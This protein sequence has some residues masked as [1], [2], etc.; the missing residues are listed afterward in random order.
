MP[1][2]KRFITAFIAIIIVIIFLSS[3]LFTKLIPAANY[4]DPYNP[5][6]DD[7]TERVPFYN[8]DPQHLQPANTQDIG[9]PPIEYFAPSDSTGVEFSYT[10][11]LNSQASV[12]IHIFNE[13]GQ[14]VTTL[15]EDS[16][17]PSGSHTIS[18]DGKDRQGEYVAEGV[19]TIGVVDGEDD[20]HFYSTQKIGIDTICPVANLSGAFMEDADGDGE[21]ELVVYG[22]AMD[23]NLN[24][25]EIMYGDEKGA[26][27]SSI[28]TEAK[29]EE[30]L[31]SLQVTLPQE[32]SYTIGLAVIDK[33]GNRAEDV[34]GGSI[35]SLLGSGLEIKIY[36]VIQQEDLG[37]LDLKNYPDDAQV[38]V[39]DT[40]PAGAA[41][42]RENWEWSNTLKY[43][44]VRSHTHEA[45]IGAGYHYFI[46]PTES[47]NIGGNN[48][49]N[50]N[51]I[52]YVYLD[53]EDPPTQIML[54]Y[55]T[56][57]GN[58]ER[59]VYWGNNKINLGGTDGTISQLRMDS[60]P[61]VGKWIRLKIPA[62]LLELEGEEIRGITFATYDGTA[63]WDKTTTS[64][65]LFERSTGTY[66][67][68]IQG[69]DNTTP[70][71]IRFSLSQQATISLTIY[72]QEN[73]VIRT[74]IDNGTKA[75][76][77]YEIT[78]DNKD[79]GGSYVE[80]GSYYYQFTAPGTPIDSDII[81]PYGVVADEEDVAELNP[82]KLGIDSQNHLYV[83]NNT[84]GRLYVFDIS[85][86]DLLYSFPVNSNVGGLAVDA[87]PGFDLLYVTDL[88]NHVV[89]RYD[90]QGTVLDEIGSP[91]TGDGQFDQPKDVVVDRSGK[92]Y[93]ADA[94]N[95]R[96]QIFSNIG[97]FENSFPV[98]V[99]DPETEEVEGPDFQPTIQALDID[100]RG[101]VYLL[102][103]ANNT[104][105]KYNSQGH[106][107]RTIGASG[108]MS[109]QFQNPVDFVI[110]INGNLYIADQMNHRVQKLDGNGFCLA[111]L[112]SDASIPPLP[113]GIALHPSGDLFVAEAQ[114][115]KVEQFKVARAH[116]VLDNI[117]ARI[118]S[119]VDNSLVAG[120]VAIQGTASARN[121]LKY[122]V[123]WGWGKEPTDWYPLI[124]SYSEADNRYHFEEHAAWTVGDELAVFD[125]N[126][127]L[128]EQWDVNTF[129]SFGVTTVRLMVYA[130]DGKTAE[131]RVTVTWG[132]V[133]LTSNPATIIS[134]DNKVTLTLPSYSVNTIG[135]L[136]ISITPTDKEK[137]ENVDY[138]RIGEFYEIRPPGLPFTRPVT[139]EMSYTDEDLLGAGGTIDETKLRIYKW[140]P[141]Q[142]MWKFLGGEI[143]TE[144]NRLSAEIKEIS[145]GEAYYVIFA[146]PARINP[147][148]FFQPPASATTEIIALS[149]LA[150]PGSQVEI[151]H[152]EESLGWVWADQ[153]NGFFSREGVELLSG[154]NV[155]TAWARDALDTMS[156]LSNQV[157]VSYAP[158][159]SIA[160]SS[161]RFMSPDYSDEFTGDI[162]IKRPVFI[163]LAGSDNDPD[164]I[165]QVYIKIF[166][167]LT[168]TAGLIIPLMET[169]LDSG[170][171]RNS[172]YFGYYTDP[173]YY[174]LGVMPGE[175]V[176][177]VSS[178][179]QTV[180][181]T[182][183]VLD[184]VPPGAPRIT[185]PT[186]PS[187]CQDTFENGQLGEWANRSGGAGGSLFLDDSD[188]SSGGS[189][190]KIV[191][192]SKG[193]D[194][195]VTIRESAYQVREYPVVSFNYKI[196]ENVRINLIVT[197]GGV[198]YELRMSDEAKH[199]ENFEQ[200]LYTTIGDLR[201]I[202]DGQWH[203]VEFNLYTLLKNC[204]PDQFDFRVDEMIM[205][206]WDV[207]GW[208]TIA[209]GNHNGEG[210]AYY[211]DNFIISSGGSAQD[212]TLSLSGL[213][214]TSGITD[215][216]FLLD[217]V[218][219]TLPDEVSEGAEWTVTYP[220]TE[221]GRWFFHARAADGVGNWGLASDY[222]LK[223]DKE[224]PLAQDPLPAPWGF[225]ATS[226]IS[227]KIMDFGGSGL[228]IDTV[229]LEVEGIVYD[230]HDGGMTYDPLT[231]TLSLKLWKVTSFTPSPIL[232][233]Q[234][235]E[236]SVIA[237][238]DLAGNPIQEAYSWSWTADYSSLTEGDLVLLTTGGGYSPSWSPDGDWIAFVSSNNIFVIQSDDYAEEEGSL[239]Q[240]TSTIEGVRNYDPAWS[241]VDEHIAFVSDREGD[242]DIWVVNS[243]GTDLMKLSQDDPD[244]QYRDRHPTWSP[245]GSQIA[246]EREGNIWIMNA[247][248]SDAYPLT[249][250]M[251]YDNLYPS[252]SSDGQWIVYTKSLY[253]DH[254]WMIGSD[255]QQ[256]FQ[257]T[258][259]DPT[260]FASFMIDNQRIVYE[261]ANEIWM[262]TIDG[263]EKKVLLDNR[264]WHDSE[265]VWNSE[266]TKLALSSTR[267]GSLNIWIMTVL[268][269]ADVRAVSEFISPNGDGRNDTVSLYYSP[270]ISNVTV[271]LRVY[272]GEGTL[273]K[274]L[275]DNERRDAGES[276]EMWDGRDEQGLVVADGAYTL[277]LQ[278][279]TPSGDSTISENKS[280]IIDTLLPS[281]S[282]KFGYPHKQ[283]EGIHYLTP[284]S[285]ITLEAAGT[286]SGV[287]RIEYSLDEGNSWRSYTSSFYVGLQ[288]TSILYRVTDGAGNQRLSN[289]IHISVDDTPPMSEI[290]PS[291]SLYY[292]GTNYYAPIH[293]TYSLYAEDNEGGAGVAG[294]H[295]SING[296]DYFNY[297]TPISLTKEG[298]NSI[299]Y[300]AVDHLDNH[301]SW[302]TIY[303]I[304]DT[305]LATCTFIPLGDTFNNGVDFFSLPD[306]LYQLSGT[307]AASG[308][309][310]MEY[311][312]D[313]GSFEEYVTPILIEEPGLHTLYY[314][315]VD[316]SGNWSQEQA[317]LMIV[318]DTLPTTQMTVS[319]PLYK[320]NGVNY[321]HSDYTYQITSHAGSVEVSID[322]DLGQ[323][324]DSYPI[325]LS[326]A[327]YG[328]GEHTISFHGEGEPSS[329]LTITVDHTSPSST[330]SI[331]PPT[332]GSAP[333]YITSL[334]RITLSA[335]DNL[336]GVA[337]MEYGVNS[338]S[339][340]ILYSQPF[341]ISIQGLSTI[342]F[343]SAD[344][345]G[346][347]EDIQ[348]IEVY[349]DDTG[350]LVDDILPSSSVYISEGRSF[351]PGDY[352]YSISAVDDEVGLDHIE[353]KINNGPY[354][355][356]TSPFSLPRGADVI[357]YKA[358]DYLGNWSEEKTYSIYIDTI[359]P[360]TT[361]SAD[362]PKYG[363]NPIYIST[364]SNI[365]FTAQDGQGAGVE[366]REYSLDD[367][368][369]WIRYYHPFKLSIPGLHSIQFRS[370]DNVGNEEPVQIADVYLDI[371]APS[372]H[373]SVSVPSAGID[374][375]YVAPASIVSLSA[376]DAG[377][378]VRNIE[379]KIDAGDWQSYFSGFNIAFPGAHRVYHRATDNLG[380]QSP[381]IAA[382]I[383]VD[384]TP[385]ITQVF[386]STPIA[387]D[388]IRK[389]AISSTSFALVSEDN[390]PGV[391]HIEVSVDEGTYHT[392]TAPVSF[393]TPGLHTISFYAFDQL[394]NRESEQ[395]YE[396]YCADTLPRVAIIP[397]G[398]VY[399]EEPNRYAPSSTM[400]TLVDTGVNILDE[401]RCQIDGGGFITYSTPIQLTEEGEHCI[402]FAAV[403]EGLQEDA[404]Q[405][406]VII[407]DTPP[408]TELSLGQPQYSSS[409]EEIFISSTT[410]IILNVTEESSGLAGLR[411]SLDNG[412]TWL[413]YS[414]S[415][416]IANSGNFTVHYQG[417]D[418][419]GNY[420][421]IKTAHL[422]VDTSP[423]TV[424]Y[425]AS[426]NLIIYEANH[427][428]PLDFSYILSATDNE[429]GVDHI[430]CNLDGLGFAPYTAPISFNG[431]G[432]H[433]IEFKAL[434]HLRLW[435]EICTLNVHVADIGVST[436]IA[437][438]EITYPLNNT[439]IVSS[440]CVYTLS[441]SS[442]AD[443]IDRIEYKID[444]G[445][446]TMYN[447]PF[448]IT[449]EG[450]HV[451]TYRGVSKTG[452]LE[453]NN[454]YRVFVDNT[455][456]GIAA[457][458]DNPDPFTPFSELNI[459]MNDTVSITAWISDNIFTELNVSLAIY[460]LQGQ[461]VR[462]L[463]ENREASAGRISSI[464]DG[465]SDSGEEMAEGDYVYQLMAA[466]RIGNIAHASG[467]I[468][469]AGSLVK[470]PVTA[471]ISDQ[472]Y[473]AIYGSRIVWEDE[474]GGNK[475]IYLY[476]LETQQ[477]T[478]ITNEA[479]DQVKPRI[480]EDFV[481]W[482]DY[483]N[484]NA[485]IY[486]Y[487]LDTQVEIR[488]T[489]DGSEQT[490]PSIH[491]SLIVWSDNRHG[492]WDIYLYDYFTG[493]ESRIT[494][495]TS[496]Q[497]NPDI[498]GY[499]IVWEDYRHGQADIYLY[500]IL[501]ESAEQRITSDSA[502]HTRPSIHNHWIVWQDSRDGNQDLYAYNLLANTEHVVAATPSNQTMPCLFG[503]FVVYQDDLNGPEDTDIYLY[504][505]ISN[506]NLLLS[507]HLSRQEHP[508]IY[509]HRIVWQDNRAG[510]WD[511]YTCLVPELSL[512]TTIRRVNLETED[513]I[514]LD[515]YGYY[516]AFTDY[517]NG[518]GDIYLKD[519]ING[520]EIRITENLTSTQCE[521]SVSGKI[522]VWQ[523]NRSG[524]WDI[525]TRRL[526]SSTE[527]RITEDL[528][529]QMHPSVYEDRIV[530]EDYRNGNSDIYYFD[531]SIG[532]ERP[533][534]L[535]PYNQTNPVIY[536]NRVVWIDDRHE[537]QSDVYLY[538]L[539]SAQE[540][541]I[542]TDSAEQ[543]QA[544]IY[545]SFVIWEDYRHG[546][547]DIYLY[548]II[549]G[550]ERQLCADISN[551]TNPAIY[552]QTIVWEDDTFGHKDIY[553]YNI[554][555]A[556]ARLVAGESYDEIY[557]NI[558]EN[559]IAWQSHQYSSHIFYAASMVSIPQDTLPPQIVDYSITPP[560]FSPDQSPGI[561]DRAAIKFALED[562]QSSKLATTV[563]IYD[564]NQNSVRHLV[565]RSLPVREHL[566]L[567]D[568]RDDNEDMVA[569]GMYT[570]TINAIDN[571][572]LSAPVISHTV[573]VDNTN[574]TLTIDQPSDGSLINND[575]PS[576]IGTLVDNLGI[577][578]DSFTLLIDNF[579]VV[580]VF[581]EES[582]FA[583][584]PESA[585]SENIHNIKAQVTDLA[586]NTAEHVIAVTVDITQPEISISGVEEGVTYSPP[587]SP[588]IEVNDLHLDIVTITLNNE[589]FVSGTSVVASGDH[590]LEVYAS[591]G[592]GN[593]NQQIV[594]FSVSNESPTCT[595]IAPYG[596]EIW[597]KTQDII[598][599]AE[600]INNDP[601]TITLSWKI[602]DGSWT[603]IVVDHANTGSFG[604]DTTAM[605]DAENYLV[606]V[607]AYDGQ[608]YAEDI[609]DAFFTIKNNTPPTAEAGDDQIVN[610]GDIV[611]FQGS[612]K[613]PDDNANIFIWNFGDGHTE[614]GTLTPT[615][616]YAD[617]GSYRVT[618]TV[619]DDDGAEGS[620]TLA[621]TVNN[622]A[623]SVNAGEDQ[624]VNKGN[625]VIFFGRFTDPGQDT[626][627]I[628]WD[629]GDGTTSEGSLIPTH[630]YAEVDIYRVTL[631]VTD[632]DGGADSDT[633]IITVN[634]LNY[635]PS[636]PGL[637]SPL[638][639]AEVT[640][641]QPPLV[642]ENSA[643]PD[644]DSIT[645]KFEVYS[646]EGMNNLLCQDFVAETEDTTSWVVS[647][648]LSD[649][650]WYYWRTRAT[651]GMAFS[652]WVSAS[653]FVNKAN[654]PPTAITMVNPRDTTEVDTLA[655]TLGVTNSTDI[656]EDVLNYTFEVYKDSTMRC[657]ITS[658][659]NI[660]EGEGGYTSWTVDLNL[661]D[662][663]WY[664][665]QATAIDEHG[666]T[667]TTGLISFFVNTTNYAP[668]MQGIYS[669]QDAEEVEAP[670]LDLVLTINNALDLDNDILTYFFEL[671]RINTFN[672]DHKQIS[673]EWPEG[674]DKTSWDV[675][676]LS[677][678]TLYFWRAKASDTLA[679]SSWVHARFFVNTDNDPP[680][681]PV[682]KNPGQYSWVRTYTPRLEL[683]PSEDPD[684]DLRNY[685]FEVYA[686]PLRENIIIHEISSTPE[687]TLSSE[688]GDNAWYYW[689]AQAQDEHGAASD[690]MET[691]TF[692]VK[693]VNHTPSAPTLN[694]PAHMSK[695]TSL[696]PLLSVNNS[697]D[698]DGDTITYE[699]EIYPNTDLTPPALASVNEHAEGDSTTSWLCEAIL[700]G[701]WYSWRA[702]AFDGIAYSE[703]MEEA[704]FS[705]NACDECS[706]ILITEKAKVCWHHSD[707]HVDGNLNFP[708][709]I[710]M[711]NLSPVGSIVIRLA[712]VEIPEQSVNFEIT[713]KKNDKWEYKD[714]DNLYGN[715]KDFKI[716]WKGAKFD[717]HGDNKFHIHTHFIAGTETELCI[718]TDHVSETLA[719]II[720]GTSIAYDEN[721]TITTAV[722]YEPQKDD[723]THVHFT[724][725]FQLTSDMT[726]KISGAL[727]LTINVA[728]YYKE[729]SAKFKLVSSFDSM[730]FPKSS[731]S[732]PD[733]LEYIIWFG[734]KMKMT[735]G[736]DLIGIEKAW[737]KKDTKHWEYK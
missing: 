322:D 6:D 58:G 386:P 366:L 215:F 257:L 500:D 13:Q 96:V 730:L 308:I 482:E 185:S 249:H 530:W 532:E 19:Y 389:Y 248:G 470:A 512:E 494:P 82:S 346:S 262:A 293:F 301:E 601:V 449:T 259:E 341:N 361:I 350:P 317:M 564:L 552:A 588:V 484:G 178:D 702:R 302:Q 298:L 517:T 436:R 623:P 66:E 117:V 414:R 41:T 370:I 63:Y 31:G 200:V 318:V 444:S 668:V 491:G 717:Y 612:F 490:N 144:N 645:Y 291:G 724:L 628:A 487:E 203:E 523:D 194:M 553:K 87:R 38:Y 501:K 127:I 584:T 643:D 397:V 573:S 376:G 471:D 77:Y 367:G 522:L 618:L 465:L 657:L 94:G 10:F 216:S 182:I 266:G 118:I 407:D 306:T 222:Q 86:G 360:Q 75:A 662:N 506:D 670:E 428:A 165:N 423:P 438:S 334:S 435:S 398:I 690:W 421:P 570:I 23:D 400:Y 274:T 309:H 461:L 280:I 681:T 255:G 725:P 281:A 602:N 457:L 359:A 65:D 230:I 92:L 507:N 698:P 598:W 159:P 210:A 4:C 404:T 642:I 344:N 456:P 686:D 692:F 716:D 380:Y 333:V 224:G 624:I 141:S 352:T 46:H 137:L 59:R 129:N 330:L 164:K 226:E 729:S 28:F 432:S 132:G 691:S 173:A 541:R 263:S 288:D 505:I 576:I 419:A 56:G 321:A 275:V 609:S 674:S 163:E 235:V 213:S 269:L 202:N 669:P 48:T 223:V 445:S 29:S 36:P 550:Q 656:D 504:N 562:N 369:T 108:A 699:F 258:R 667:A 254:L 712:E 131:D 319:S 641:S 704:T 671:D 324:Y 488:L 466:D 353:V 637:S 496:D 60:L 621:V 12:N 574:P 687:L 427:Y 375:V 146:N 426:G 195:G 343:R 297:T 594:N 548:N 348:S 546:N 447:I 247:D 310:H 474:R 684:R 356:Y 639:H 543:I 529:D 665:W 136:L 74:L 652:N 158:S 519:L 502:E 79:D 1:G 190:L 241:P 569:D 53:P 183:L 107:L 186:H 363:T 630:V 271:S 571:A 393:D 737:T 270:T 603:E 272:D 37:A 276:I 515:L 396:I 116:L 581:L 683:Y 285:Q 688:L 593:E 256:E 513:Q 476:D 151:F 115:G 685:I 225:S 458:S 26:F 539:G 153:D 440:H 347:I 124:T 568:G 197:I 193:G 479:H 27:I 339:N 525:Y 402:E 71:T 673:G 579:A 536:G 722:E 180:S 472:T 239:L 9:M 713:D 718:H 264:S 554:P 95:S 175:S 583:Y 114:E 177:M 680:S 204:M 605:P 260:R 599:S 711:D 514:H 64:S 290:M 379:Y 320:A 314:K 719:V 287:S 595:L 161:L 68:M 61:P 459:G 323:T 655:P 313:E 233:G 220:D 15:A 311:K 441:A 265:P 211:I 382:E 336:S 51:L 592:T 422:T 273:V 345:V 172:V 110:D 408:L 368:A 338:T 192:E 40:V 70:S 528:A 362:A 155:F 372:T 349:L 148:V 130:T 383:F 121:F 649:N 633:L 50:T 44:G 580:G 16:A 282:H 693:K 418:N 585:L 452:S 244:H 232:D 736:R 212:P 503:D 90:S 76:G 184:D 634:R 401:I 446:F 5:G 677:D 531:L 410:P 83:L 243:D 425:I 721:K 166:G 81:S 143:D 726:I 511:I 47:L 156:R 617:N 703:W 289:L 261:K 351:A 315:A 374:P 147:P 133:V 486:L 8:V 33:S 556:T 540:R 475:D 437:T 217:S 390:V 537:G 538:D 167:N 709:G 196:P 477:E 697:H 661:D 563:I 735:S 415:F 619:I 534:V 140:D 85:T 149:G 675:S 467:M 72:N 284:A 733:Q 558:F 176:T 420:E 20:L 157:I 395:I 679:E 32:G 731:E 454:T 616:V 728:D 708:N 451:I 468:T 635:P 234:V 201:V 57:Y 307:D 489:S 460:D 179:D 469:L 572:Q 11:L 168:D 373:L 128:H 55:Y 73:E 560:S 17:L 52:Q 433:R 710:W 611:E 99:D 430:E 557:P 700:E 545:D 381:V 84:D 499:H 411:Y 625:T 43:S 214:D 199:V 604:W 312:V 106:F 405:Y 520:D 238:Q 586:G 510:Q 559:I 542:T 209:M 246:F 549:T 417:Y 97:L 251:V 707:I 119:P 413:A 252:W 120:G 701:S 555:I 547:A 434:N 650:T 378:G 632:D 648:E 208:S 590:S 412:N 431:Y 126:G 229:Q 253:E 676:G 453:A 516:L 597:E 268:E 694:S 473:P 508:A 113:T 631:T 391:D 227:I 342:Y 706:Y 292:D 561:K 35:E 551:Q 80:S 279:T 640:A 187:L 606:K 101:N 100:F 521:P 170:I 54:Q 304:V 34:I 647:E 424:R 78:W 587:V 695:A 365:Y 614:E 659:S 14:Q 139:L 620:D 340:W 296:N 69:Q 720:N 245:D 30:S 653:F 125:I 664:Y 464:W 483:R 678:N 565:D 152:N 42:P 622:V 300:R 524:N 672:S 596:G 283:S 591:D 25:Y 358:K 160:V 21:Q 228:D 299:A 332:Y 18:W 610:E 636:I 394:N 387:D 181:D 455:P 399:N 533:L 705:S 198:W 535:D 663:T 250:D 267:N 406:H 103:N 231:E 219:D 654:D 567:W 294:I 174:T 7:V 409:E 485:D 577:D 392:Y 666:A 463:E 3:F 509:G 497:I 498:L 354:M 188:P 278:A 651:D 626:H 462:Q 111:R 142:Q 337:Y 478:Q 206:E 295:V 303:I 578:Q 150:E 112:G 615:H 727:N 93:V 682:L 335:I 237:A 416:T 305:G 566:F 62:R 89:S 403:I 2:W 240:L 328:E 385:P 22:T 627:T 734:D 629:F 326:L 384:T 480:Y 527:I 109:G 122:S 145:H 518:F 357:K 277:N 24:R 218:A 207:V 450:E 658:V 91:G 189:C 39:E 102:D 331:E 205:A 575:Q 526:D 544:D 613:D 448:K 242:E 371:E 600:D 388:G 439:D 608:Y 723:N 442:G 171:Y 154:E 329:T 582:D 607:T 696:T 134:S 49:Y 660:S 355:E 377:A 638:D 644:E 481:V 714:K 104:I 443:W 135:G 98:V 429:S 45:R 492:N 221:S 689:R 169:A 191:N 325:T 286:G 316:N 364:T 732:S 589:P 138:Q 105:L 162:Q 123:E 236:C 88:A 327:S 495:D 493:I 646:D 67:V 715:I